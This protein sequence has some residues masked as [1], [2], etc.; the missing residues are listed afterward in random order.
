MF[1]GDARLEAIEKIC[2]PDAE[3]G[4]DVLDGDE[5]GSV[6]AVAQLGTVYQYQGVLDRAQALHEEAAFLRGQARGD[7]PTVLN[8]LGGVALT[9]GEVERAEKLT[10]ESL[11]L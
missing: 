5:L 1:A 3:L 8:S 10:S 6:R 4:L 2:N 9:R 7:T 11:A